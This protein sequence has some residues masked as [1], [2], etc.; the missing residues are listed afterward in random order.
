MIQ[1]QLLT[2]ARSGELLGLRP[3]DFQH[4]S[5]KVW[6]VE[7]GEHKTAHHGKGRTL[8]FGPQARE[9]LQP[10]LADRPVDKPLF[11]PIEAEFERR[12]PTNYTTKHPPGEVY[13][14]RSYRRAIWRACLKVHRTRK[15]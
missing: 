11:S 2:G 6:E 13:Q 1:L 12:G 5:D 3:I 7:L 9:V 14:P 15:G 10:F 4:T 8:Y